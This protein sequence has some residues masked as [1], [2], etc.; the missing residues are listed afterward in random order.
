MKDKIN[1]SLNRTFTVTGN[2]NQTYRKKHITRL[3]YIQEFKKLE[4]FC[5]EEKGFL[6]V[7]VLNKSKNKKK[8]ERNLFN[9]PESICL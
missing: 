6:F 5:S 4:M 9:R 2:L 3:N 1:K 7:F 8:R